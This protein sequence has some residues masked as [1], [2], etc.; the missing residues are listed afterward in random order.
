MMVKICQF[1]ISEIAYDYEHVQEM[2]NKACGRTPQ[3]YRVV[4]VC[5]TR[6]GILF[7]LVPTEVKATYILAPFSGETEEEISADIRSRYQGKYQTLGLIRLPELFL[8]V[9]SKEIELYV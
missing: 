2:L 7:N 5:Q 3:K 9:F 6:E 4:G 1:S 8:G